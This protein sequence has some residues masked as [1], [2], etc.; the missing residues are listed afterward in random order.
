MRT[1]TAALLVVSVLAAAP[2][3]APAPP[4]VAPRPPPPLALADRGAREPR[5]RA[6]RRR[7]LRRTDLPPHPEQRRR[8]TR[9]EVPD[10]RER[11]VRGVLLQ[12]THPPR[13][14]ARVLHRPGGARS[15][16]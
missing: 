8:G 10:R 9:R 1:R 11:G 4:F 3:A 6:R 2:P 16:P 13:R 14:R 5:A 15:G 7:P 12:P